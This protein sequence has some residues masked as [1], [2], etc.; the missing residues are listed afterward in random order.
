RFDFTAQEQRLAEL[1]RHD[2]SVLGIVGYAQPEWARSDAAQRR[3]VYGPPR[4]LDEFVRAT[5]PVV[6]HFG[7]I[8]VWELW[9][10]PWVQGWTWASDAAEFR[11]LM[12]RWL[13]AVRA[14][15]PDVVIIGG[16]SASYVADHL[17][18][19]PAAWRG[20]DGDSNHPYKDVAL[21][22]LRSGAELRYIDYGVQ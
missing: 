2:V 9:N 1:H 5:V 12:R 4:D 19:F 6:A 17:A 8:A 18:P 20:L 10:E 16:S 11:R 21:P 7:D 22:S 3:R 15:R 13:D 14:V